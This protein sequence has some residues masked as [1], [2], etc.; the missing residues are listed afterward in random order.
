MSQWL[1]IALKT[2][3]PLTQFART[4]FSSC[5]RP[6]KA[7]PQVVDTAN[8]LF[9]VTEGSTT[10]V[11]SVDPTISTA[12]TISTDLLSSGQTLY[13]NQLRDDSAFDLETFLTTVISMRVGRGT[14]K[15]LTR[16]QDQTGATAVNNPGIISL[17][18]T[19]ITTSSLGVGI[20]F[21]NLIDTFDALDPAYLPR[22]VWQMTSKTRNT[23]IKSLDA[24]DRSLF[25]P[26]PNIDGFDMLL[27]RPIVINQSLDQLGTANGVP[28]VFG[29][30]YDGIELVGS[31]VSIRNLIE[32]YADSFRSALIAFTRWGSAGLTAAA[33]QKI[34]LASA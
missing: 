9:L 18:Q 1:T 26:A 15:L 12:G 20:S 11:S 10:A 13:S 5:G 2:Y 27:G 16:G 32:R 33:L 34:V 8:G 22:A 4:R 29:S 3:A 14:E 25:V 7:S 17:A 31:E 23:L 19:A 24:T 21:D 6:V 30:L 28:V